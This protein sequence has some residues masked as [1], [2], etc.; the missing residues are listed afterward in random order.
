MAA[1]A[2]ALA[3]EVQAPVADNTNLTGSFDFIVHYAP[4]TRQQD[5]DPDPDQP[6]IF[7]ALQRDL[8]L[9][10]VAGKGPIERL[11]IKGASKPTAD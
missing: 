3:S 11:V 5:S 9:Q 1:L 10:L 6:S 8:G 4:D 2:L 7:T